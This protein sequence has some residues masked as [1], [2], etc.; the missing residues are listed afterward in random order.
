MIAGIL[1]APLAWLLLAFGQDTSLQAF[2]DQPDGGAVDTHSLGRPLLLLAAAGVLL[3]LI[4]TLRFS[5][6]GAATTG[7]LYAGSYALMLAAPDRVLSLLPR[8]VSI[9]GLHADTT[10]PLRTGTTV[11]VGALLLVGL[12]SI[13]RWRRWPDPDLAGWD[14]DDDDYD[15]PRRALSEPDIAAPDRTPSSLLSW[16]SSL[17]G[18]AGPAYRTRGP[19]Q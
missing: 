15:T 7:I 11:L 2:A 4:A 14:D 12:L 5:P 8:N 19:A 16:T 9:G 18:G 6:L 1:I 3:G 17:R 13:G 10:I